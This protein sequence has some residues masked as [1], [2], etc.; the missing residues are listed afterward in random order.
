ME[1]LAWKTGSETRE[2]QYRKVRR[3]EVEEIFSELGNLEL[4]GN[5]GDNH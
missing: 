4:K 5:E 3:R 1:K 2:N